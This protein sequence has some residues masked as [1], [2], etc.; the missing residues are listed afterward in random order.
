MRGFKG[1]DPTVYT[2]PRR[3]PIPFTMGST[4]SGDAKSRRVKGELF[5]AEDKDFRAASLRPRRWIGMFFA[6][7]ARANAA[8]IP[9]EPQMSTDIGGV[10]GN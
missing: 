10:A 6:N 5:V 8:P 2:R 3:G 4:S 9:L 1:M 7:N